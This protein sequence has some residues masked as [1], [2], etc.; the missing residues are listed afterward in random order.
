VLGKLS[1]VADAHLPFTMTASVLG[2]AHDL[3]ISSAPEY[4]SSYAD[5]VTGGLRT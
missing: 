4:V 3:V 5:L 2:F 1:Q